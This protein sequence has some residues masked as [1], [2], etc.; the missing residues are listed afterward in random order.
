MLVV[1]VPVVPVVSA[2]AGCE[3]TVYLFTVVCLTG[4]GAAVLVDATGAIF[5]GAGA[6]VVTAGF[7]AV[8]VA[9]VV[10]AALEVLVVG[11]SC[12]AGTAT[13]GAGAFTGCAPNV[14]P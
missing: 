13:I 10:G 6:A 3:L 12:A 5:T 14:D 9:T 7:G 11:C 1:G 2:G 4:A 8:V